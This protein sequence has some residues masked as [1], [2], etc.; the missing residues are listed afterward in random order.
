MTER[1]MQVPC[2]QAAMTPSG[3]ATSTANTM[4]VAASDTVG[5][6]FS[7]IV[8]LTG[9]SDSSEVPR[10]PCRSCHSQAPNCTTIGRSSPRLARI[11]S[12]FSGVAASPARI[13]AGSPGLRRRIRKTTKATIPMTGMVARSRFRTNAAMP[14]RSSRS[15]LVDVPERR[16]RRLEHAGQVGAIGARLVVDPG[17]DPHHVLERLLL[18]RRGDFLLLGGIGRAHEGVAQ[19][20]DLGVLGPAEPAAVLALAV[21]PEVL[22]RRQHVGVDPGRV[23]HV[24]A[25]LR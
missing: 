6:I 13:A 15:A 9:W 22:H 1:S 18:D 20:L 19:L 12:M 24:P 16:E 21:D 8:V 17:R 2:F 7:P 10:S 4:V 11:F 5:P 25:T 14:V 3:T 23:E